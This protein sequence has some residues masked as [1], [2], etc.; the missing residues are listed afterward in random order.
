MC[1]IDDGRK[2]IYPEQSEAAG[3]Q[4]FSCVQTCCQPGVGLQY[5]EPGEDDQQ[6]ADK[7]KEQPRTDDGPSAIRVP[8][9]KRIIQIQ[10]NAL[11]NL[12][13]LLAGCQIQITV[14]QEEQ[15]APLIAK[16]DAALVHNR[17]WNELKV[18][19]SY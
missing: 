1:C 7:G 11:R 10:E 2:D 6:Q 8:G 3:D 19:R 18:A 4:L 12:V 13:K 14:S 16:S 9:L 5:Q 15:D 17:Y